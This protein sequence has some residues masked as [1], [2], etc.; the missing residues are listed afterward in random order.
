MVRV[1]IVA[2]APINEAS[3]GGIASFIRGFIRFMPP[4]FAVDVVGAAVAD[5]QPGAEWHDIEL[6]ERNVR[7]FPVAR[8]EDGRRTGRI[9]A[10]LRIVLGT[11]RHRRAIP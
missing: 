3:S 2:P 5:N 11:L 8:L 4:D 10:K 1:T 6:A 9:P 7:F